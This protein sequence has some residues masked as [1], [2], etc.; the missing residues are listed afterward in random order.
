MHSTVRQRW[1]QQE[2]ELVRGM[3]LLGSL[4]DQAVQCLRERRVADLA[5]LAERNFATR[6]QLY[7]AGVVG[8]K[9]LQMVQLAS[10]LGLGAKFT[11]SGGALLCIRKSGEG[12]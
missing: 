8:Q 3:Q 9:N 12:L 6:L 10:Q 1:E 7:G 4:A 11:G 2:G 5:A